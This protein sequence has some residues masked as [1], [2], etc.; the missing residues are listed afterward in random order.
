MHR[1]LISNISP[2]NRKGGAL[3]IVSEIWILCKRA[4]AKLFISVCTPS[5][6][7]SVFT[8][9]YTLLPPFQLSSARLL[10]WQWCEPQIW[11]H[12]PHLRPDLLRVLRLDGWSHDHIIAWDPVDRRRDFVLVARLQAIDDAQDLCGVAAGRG[13]VGEDGADNLLRVDE[14][15]GADGEGD[16]FAVDI[17]CVLMVEPFKFSRSVVA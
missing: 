12:N 8:D 5:Q 4:A 3:D 1:L 16:A 14:E 6:Q 2:D 13:G 11:L 7:P 10:L 17:G 9:I 15:D